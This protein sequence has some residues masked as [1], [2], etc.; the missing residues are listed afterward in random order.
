VSVEEN[1][2]FIQ[3]TNK[4]YLDI[5]G[6]NQKLLIEKGVK[7]ENIY[8]SN[9]CTMTNMDLFFSHRGHKGKRGSNAAMMQLK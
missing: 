8:L 3:E 5:P 2:K 6:I 4:Y 1:V 7:S 9:L